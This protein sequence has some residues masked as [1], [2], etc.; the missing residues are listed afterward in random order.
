MTGQRVS[1]YRERNS[2]ADRALDIL[3]MFDEEHMVVGGVEVATRLSV[4]RST[5]YRYLQSLVSARFLEEAPGGGF[6]LGLRL[7]EL[8]RLARGIYGLSEIAAP[9]LVDLAA[10]TGETA[11][12]TRRMGDFIVCLDLAESR[13]QRVHISYERG[14]VLPISTGASATVLL[15]WSDP[16]DVRKLLARRRLERSTDAPPADLDALV[17]RMERVRADGYAVARTELDPDLVSIAA[18][19]WSNGKVV[20]S[21]SVAAVSSRVPRSK[22]RQFAERA[23]EAAAKISKGL[24]LVEG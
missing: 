17:D 24:E 13:D 7:M 19:I 14:T 5:A 10:D 20:A 2:T 12:L 9:V 6:R 23:R 4:A 16:E 3:D 15:A 11:L 22:E 8:G 18:P 1:G 21:V